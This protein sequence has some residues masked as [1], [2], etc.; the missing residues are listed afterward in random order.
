MY[1]YTVLAAQGLICYYSLHKLVVVA[2]STNHNWLWC[3]LQV[4]DN[5]N[6]AVY[7]F[8]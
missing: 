2:H 7:F 3:Q 5:L 6:F 4:D 8:K 1:R